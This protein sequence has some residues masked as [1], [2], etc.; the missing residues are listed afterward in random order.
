MIF[1]LNYHVAL[2]SI[3]FIHMYQC[4]EALPFGSRLNDKTDEGVDEGDVLKS[5]YHK[6]TYDGK[7][8]IN[9]SKLH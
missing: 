6:G 2:M 3:C 4:G 5:G 8:T 1:L 7:I 9:S